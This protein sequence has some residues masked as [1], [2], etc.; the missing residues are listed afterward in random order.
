MNLSAAL[1]SIISVAQLSSSALGK[2]S[3]H[4][5]SRDAP[6]S[7]IHRRGGNFDD[8]RAKRNSW[9]D[10]DDDDDDIL[11]NQLSREY[12]TSNLFNSAPACNK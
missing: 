11:I 1:L 4:V 7:E 6:I 10:R 9:S 2:S 12:A 5:G 3:A 8:L